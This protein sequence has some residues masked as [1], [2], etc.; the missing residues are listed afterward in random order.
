MLKNGDLKGVCVE[1]EKRNLRTNSVVPVE[2]A[3][4]WTLVTDAAEIV[5]LDILAFA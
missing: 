2:T 5:Q 1:R 3:T 4:L